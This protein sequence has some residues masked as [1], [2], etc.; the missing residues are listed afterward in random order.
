[1]PHTLLSQLWHSLGKEQIPTRKH[2]G[3]WQ[4]QTAAAQTLLAPLEL[5]LLGWLPPQRAHKCLLEDIP[6]VL[7][8]FFLNLYASDITVSTLRWQQTSKPVPSIYLR[9]MRQVRAQKNR[10]APYHLPETKRSALCS[11]T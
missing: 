11:V 4:S 9:L 8:L 3:I 10:S 5:A 2:R 7:Q 1:M 6:A